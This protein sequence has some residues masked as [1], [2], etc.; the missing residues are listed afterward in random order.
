MVNEF[1]QYRKLNSNFLK[2]K[3]FVKIR[4]MQRFIIIF[5]DKSKMIFKFKTLE[6]LNNF[7][8]SKNY[9]LIFFKK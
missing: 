4:I 3:L 8:F 2:L 9:L 1:F 5:R 6:N 7:N